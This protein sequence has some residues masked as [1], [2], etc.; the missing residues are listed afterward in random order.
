MAAS[1]CLG[2]DCDLCKDACS[3]SLALGGKSSP[4]EKLI[5]AKNII[6]GGNYG[7]NDIKNIFQCTKCR[8][9]ELICPEDIE[10]TR[11]I[12]EARGKYVL[13]KGVKFGGQRQIIRSI[14]RYGNPF[15]QPGSRIAWLHEK[16]PRASDTLLFIG[17][18]CSYISKGMAQASFSILKKLNIDFTIL[19]EDESCCGYFV[20][21][22]GDHRGADAIIKRNREIFKGLNIKRII[23]IC[24]GCTT[25]LKKYYDMDIEVL[26]ITQV[27][28]N[29]IKEGDIR[30][31]ELKESVTFHDSCNISRSLGIYQ[32][33]RDILKK[34]G[35][36][37]VEMEFSRERALCCGADGGMKVTFPNLAL[38]IG[39]VR[40]NGMASQCNRILTVCPFC[41]YNLREAS[42]KYDMG[43]DVLNILEVLD[44]QMTAK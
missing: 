24:P 2:V 4:R 23:S 34:L 14:G 12:D 15:N 28:A 6:T 7:L 1:E 3:I 39:K 26:H 11:F 5:S 37:V 20:Y 31:K 27:I 8:A 16:Y 33:P 22:T 30:F 19:G 41:V 36:E 32:E 25:F 43:I 21:N 42:D 9:C 13:E 38:K 40:L 17:C 18:F 35:Y 10:I 44:R 29:T